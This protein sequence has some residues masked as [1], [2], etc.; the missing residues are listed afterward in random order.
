MINYELRDVYVTDHKPS[1]RKVHTLGKSDDEV[2]FKYH[3]ELQQYN[4]T[5]SEFARANDKKGKYERGSLMQL[6]LDPFAGAERLP[7]GS[8]F[9]EVQDRELDSSLNNEEK[10]RAQYETLKANLDNPSE[11]SEEDMEELRLQ[12]LSELEALS[13]N[14][15]DE[16]EELLDKEL[17]VFQKG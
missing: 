2:F 7:N 17:S 3:Q 1:P 5:K 9:Y 11:V 14:T 4:N 16:F 6:I 15:L 12:A 8:L 13:P 10:L